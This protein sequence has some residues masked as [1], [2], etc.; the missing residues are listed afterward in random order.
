MEDNVNDEHEGSIRKYLVEKN[1]TKVND[2]V[3]KISIKIMNEDV[4]HRYINDNE[5][6]KIWIPIKS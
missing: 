6:E 2:E 5:T 1:D 3:R 4:I